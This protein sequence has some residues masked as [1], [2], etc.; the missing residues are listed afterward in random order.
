MLLA[1]LK[2]KAAEKSKDIPKIHLGKE[3]GH[4]TGIPQ[5][6]FQ[7][8]LEKYKYIDNEGV[9]SYCPVSR[10]NSW[11]RPRNEVFSYHFFRDGLN[12]ATYIPDID[13]SR[14]KVF[15]TKTYPQHNGLVF[16]GDEGR[17]WGVEKE[18]L[19]SMQ[20]IS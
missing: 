19:F 9:V 3:I 13:L 14:E 18:G 10:Y 5:R 16:H 15:T 17:V 7:A 20:E 8:V 6:I 1:D 2:E 12:V 11:E 4:A